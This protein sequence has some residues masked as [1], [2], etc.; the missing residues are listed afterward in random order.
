M[1]KLEL[2]E[3]CHDN[4]RAFEPV[5]NFGTSIYDV[6]GEER[7]YSDTVVQCSKRRICKKLVEYLK[8][9]MDKE[10]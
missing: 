5:V 2:E 8:R 4:C 10:E 7:Q 9:T 6:A 3:Y 1:I